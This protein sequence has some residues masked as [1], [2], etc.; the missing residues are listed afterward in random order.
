MTLGLA[1]CGGDPER[2]E[3]A[4]VGCNEACDAQPAMCPDVDVEM[5]TSTCDAQALLIEPGSACEEAYL[6]FKAC[7]QGATFTC[8]VP[9]RF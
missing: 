8:A 7:E 9:R 1:A 2:S 6:A 4:V 3:A 5:C